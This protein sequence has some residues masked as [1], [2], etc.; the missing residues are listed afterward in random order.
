AYLAWQRPRLLR[1]P[2]LALAAL[3]FLVTIGSYV[4]YNLQTPLGTLA[5]VARQRAG[6]NRAAAPGP[7]SYAR[8]LGNELGPLGLVLAGAVPRRRPRLGP[9]AT[10]AIVALLAAPSVLALAQYYRAVEACGSHSQVLVAAAA[11]L[12]APPLRGQPVV[13]DNSLS[14]DARRG[15]SEPVES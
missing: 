8:G 1:S 13:V 12:A 5:D 9:A 14:D 11:L 7:A 2:W 15:C 4:A 3:L 10:T 6:S